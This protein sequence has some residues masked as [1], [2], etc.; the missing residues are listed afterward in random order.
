MI[1][2]PKKQVIEVLELNPSYLIGKSLFLSNH[3]SNDVK[4]VDVN[5]K[6]T[7][8]RV[9]CPDLCI[10]WVDANSLENEIIFDHFGPSHTGISVKTILDLV[11]K[12]NRMT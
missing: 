5:L 1:K 11:E 3:D 6:G 10:K 12:Q 2:I 8:I 9:E 4:I 7:H